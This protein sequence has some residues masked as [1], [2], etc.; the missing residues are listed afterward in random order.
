MVGV[1]FYHFQ[2]WLM[3]TLL[4][5]SPTWGPNFRRLLEAEMSCPAGRRRERVQQIYEPMG[6]FTV[7]FGQ[8]GKAGGEV[9]VKMISRPNE[10]ILMYS[11]TDFLEETGCF[12]LSCMLSGPWQ[13]V[14]IGKIW[15]ESFVEASFKMSSEITVSE[16]AYLS[17]IAQS[18]LGLQSR[19]WT[20]HQACL[21]R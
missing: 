15:L 5:F 6:D 8:V 19:Q 16:P 7:W 18:F 2:K 11:S 17:L 1:K 12:M 14:L 20:Q 3:K 13:S 4:D 21:N 9:Q 10:F